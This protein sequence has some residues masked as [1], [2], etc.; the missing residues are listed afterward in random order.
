MNN[1]FNKTAKQLKSS[2]T[3]LFCETIVT[4]YSERRATLTNYGKILKFDD[5]VLIVGRDEKILK[6]EGE[7]LTL[8]EMASDHLVIDGVIDSIEIVK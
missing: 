5:C 6:I 8:S 2:V 3:N 7:K 4:L 1:L